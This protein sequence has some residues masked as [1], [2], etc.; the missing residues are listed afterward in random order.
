[1]SAT[2]RAGRKSISARRAVR[3]PAAQ[4]Q[5]F[6]AVWTE[7]RRM[8]SGSLNRTSSPSRWSLSAASATAWRDFRRRQAARLSARA[9][10]GAGLCARPLRARRRCGT[11][12]SPDR[13]TG[14][15]PRLQGCGGA[16][17]D[18]RG[19]DRLGLDI[20]SLTVLE[21]YERLAALRHSAHGVVTDVLNRLFSN[22]NRCCGPP[23]ASG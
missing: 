11:R 17:G 22:D 20:G 3:H 14:P 2:T 10:A 16:G 19:A 12:H 18:H 9:D 23:A 8:R 4:G 15:Q 5:P 6:L 21:R 1:M 13:R 7:R